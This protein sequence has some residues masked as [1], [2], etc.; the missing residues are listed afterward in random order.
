VNEDP[1]LPD[2]YSAVLVLDKITREMP[3]W[4]NQSDLLTQN[5]TQEDTEDTYNVYRNK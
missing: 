1:G 3:K 2:R 4:L 5:A